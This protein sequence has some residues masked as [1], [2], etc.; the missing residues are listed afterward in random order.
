MLGKAMGEEQSTDPAVPLAK[1]APAQTTSQTVILGYRKPAPP[2]RYAAVIRVIMVVVA[3]VAIHLAAI[4]LLN[5]L[6]TLREWL[7]GGV[8]GTPFAPITSNLGEDEI[9]KRYLYE[10]LVYLGL[11]LLTQWWFRSP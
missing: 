3:V 4:C 11:F 6:L 10:A 5:P 1:I 9:Q 2:Q 7:G 8:I